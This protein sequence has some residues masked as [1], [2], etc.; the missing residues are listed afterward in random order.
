M[1]VKVNT[2]GY[3]TVLVDDQDISNAVTGLDIRSRPG[4]V[5]E[6]TVTLRANLSLESD[7][8]A[9]VDIR[10]YDALVALGWTPPEGD[11]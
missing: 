6:I 8:R 7:A 2:N 3:G 11:A 4:E 1:N 5:T 10:T 9:R